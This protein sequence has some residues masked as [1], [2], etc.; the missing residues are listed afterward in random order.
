MSVPAGSVCV[1]FTAALSGYAEGDIT[2]TATNADQL[3]S[4]M[5]GQPRLVH[6][7]LRRR[8]RSIR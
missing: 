2:W 5:L 4:S 3:F 1:V 7:G 8:N 6:D